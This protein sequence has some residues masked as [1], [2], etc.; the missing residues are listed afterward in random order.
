MTYAVLLLISL[1]IPSLA[2]CQPASPVSPLVADRIRLF[3]AWAESQMAYRGQP[4]LAIGIVHDQ[5]LVWTRG[6][7][8]ADRERGIPATPETLF[9]IASIT[10]TFTATA[11][12]QLRDQGK[13]QLDDPVAK[14]L[15]SFA[16]RPREPGGHPITIR[17]LLMH[18]SGL[19]READF[20]YWT[21]QQFPTREAIL[22]ALPDQEQFFQA[23]TRWK[24]SNLA[25]MLAGEIVTSVS[26][27]PWEP[28][29]QAAH[30]GPA[31]DDVDG[32]RCARGRSGKPRLGLRAA[33]PGSVALAEDRGRADAGSG[34]GSGNGVERTGSRQVRCDAVPDRSGRRRTGPEGRVPARD[35]AGA[36]AQS[37]LA[38]R[39]GH[40]LSGATRRRPHPRRS[41]R[42]AAG[43]AHADHVRRE[44]QDRRHRPDERGRWEPRALRRPG[45]RPDRVRAGAKDRR[46]GDRALTRRLERVRGTLP[47]CVGR[48]AG[49][50]AQHGAR[51]VRPVEPLQPRSDCSPAAPR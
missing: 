17:H 35:A 42:V 13:L 4:G 34:A 11:I 31:R 46:G 15:P 51:D 50:P 3:E 26:G 1:A 6:F 45:L 36:L 43:H 2:W 19:P 49:H 37:G 14:H 33:A 10:K 16:V 9:R 22:K 38:G 25:V 32:D 30:P 21:T 23:E 40:R 27:E 28:L 18:V 44:G 41:R 7:G 5:D 20:P 24:Y 8:Q 47:E 39:A 48:R 12:M 29:R